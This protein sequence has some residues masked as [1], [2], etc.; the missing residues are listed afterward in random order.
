MLS[1][2]YQEDTL[3]P[4]NEMLTR[5]GRRLK[6]TSRFFQRESSLCTLLDPSHDPRLPRMPGMNCFAAL[7]KNHPPA[8]LI[9]EFQMSA[10]ETPKAA[11]SKSHLHAGQ[12]RREL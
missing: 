1:S 12:T 10:E 7:R 11:Q 9:I 4:L 8:Q 6:D 5:T 2:L 3:R